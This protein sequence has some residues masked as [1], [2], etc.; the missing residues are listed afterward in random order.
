MAA[1]L[2]F[3]STDRAGLRS[4]LQIP[5]HSVSG[6]RLIPAQSCTPRLVLQGP[7]DLHGK[8]ERFQ[9]VVVA[10]IHSSGASPESSL[11]P[12]WPVQEAPP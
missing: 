4:Q 6:Q 8:E 7:Q 9:V 12:A 10:V 5:E 11:P 3:S 1:G 2:H